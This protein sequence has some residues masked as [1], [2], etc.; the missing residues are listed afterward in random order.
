M[1]VHAQEMFAGLLLHC[2]C[3]YLRGEMHYFTGPHQAKKGEE[4]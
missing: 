2:L 1:I 4:R 3:R